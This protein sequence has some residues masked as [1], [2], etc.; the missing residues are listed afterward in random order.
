MKGAKS[1]DGEEVYYKNALNANSEYCW[2]VKHPVINAVDTAG[3]S[4][5][6]TVGTKTWMAWGIDKTT[7]T[8]LTN[9]GGSGSE[10]WSGS[11]PLSASFIGGTDGSAIT[12]ADIVLS[13]IHI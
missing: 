11:K 2:W 4:N 10:F 5:Q 3:S 6:I 12:N 1:P 13:L 7:A 8:G 9:S